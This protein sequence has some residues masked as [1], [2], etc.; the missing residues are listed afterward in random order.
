M[1]SF[2]FI[3]LIPVLL[4]ASCNNK[5]YYEELYVD[6]DTKY[7]TVSPR[8]WS[9]EDFR[10]NPFDPEDSNC[11]YF[12][13]D[14]VEPALTNYI[15]NNGIMTAYLTDKDGRS[16][17]PLPF[18]NYFLDS[19]GYKWTEQITCEFA[20]QRVSFIVKYNDFEIGML[21]PE[22]TFMVRFMW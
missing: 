7:Y 12:Y 14:I 6:V 22:C 20:P 4:V 10:P 3:L 5:T 17:T 2:R 1:K 13:C 15:F 19:S 8:S 11:T 18:D 9:L 21:P 16:I